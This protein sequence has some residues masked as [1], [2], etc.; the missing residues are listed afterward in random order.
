MGLDLH[1]VEVRVPLIVTI[2]SPSPTCSSFDRFRPL[3]WRI[4]VWGGSSLL[5]V[6]ISQLLEDLANSHVVLN[7]ITYR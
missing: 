4:Y 1:L 7:D 6:Y 2:N 5:L 3:V